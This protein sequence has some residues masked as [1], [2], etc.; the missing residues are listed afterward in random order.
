MLMTLWATMLISRKPSPISRVTKIFVILAHEVLDGLLLRIGIEIN[1]GPLVNV[2]T[3]SWASK[4]FESLRGTCPG[5]QSESILS[6]LIPQRGSP[7]GRAGRV[8]DP[9]SG[10]RRF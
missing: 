5:G 3:P 1:D 8:M 7:A 9:L 6:R 4:S 10:A 2:L